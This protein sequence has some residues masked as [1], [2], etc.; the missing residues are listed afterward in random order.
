MFQFFRNLMSTE[1]F[2][3][4]ILALG[5]GWH[6]YHHSFPWDYRAGEYGNYRLNLTTDFI[7][8]CAKVGLVYNLKTAKPSIVEER[9][10]RTG[11]GTR[12]DH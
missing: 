12:S 7:N 11:D 4:S 10:K 5:E 9:S 2:T 1:N 8:I 6:N 3:V